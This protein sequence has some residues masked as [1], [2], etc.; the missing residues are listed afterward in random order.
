MGRDKIADTQTDTSILWINPALGPGRLKK[1]WNSCGVSASATNA[2]LHR[3]TVSN[4]PVPLHQWVIILILN[5]WSRS[6]SPLELICWICITLFS[7]DF[8]SSMHNIFMFWTVSDCKK[9][10]RKDWQIVAAPSGC[11]DRS[12]VITRRLDSEACSS[13]PNQHSTIGREM[14]LF[15]LEIYLLKN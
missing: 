8:L 14:F 15:K 10:P 6:A 4:C 13:G 3:V 1:L 11:W 7:R 9:V 2:I 12:L 5:Y